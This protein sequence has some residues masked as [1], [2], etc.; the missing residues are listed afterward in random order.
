MVHVPYKGGR[1]AMQA[2][3]KGETCQDRLAFVDRALERLRQSALP[4]G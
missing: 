3:L 2:V 4:R 1:E